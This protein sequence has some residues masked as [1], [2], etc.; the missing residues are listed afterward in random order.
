MGSN[1]ILFY[2]ASAKTEATAADAIF[3]HRALLGPFDY[4]QTDPGLDYTSGVVAQ[5]NKLLAV[6]HHI[7]LVARPQSTGIERDVQ[8][9][10]RFIRELCLS[11]TLQEHWSLPRILAVAQFLINEDPN[12]NS[13][14]SPADLKFGRRD[15]A[16]LDIITKADLDEPAA[17]RKS[18]HHRHLLAELFEIRS[19]WSRLKAEWALDKTAP[20]LLAP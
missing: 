17:Q 20:N 10:K 7:G 12:E 16:M 19:I 1:F 4:L 11:H 9:A 14:F 5:V 15:A 6:H 2:A 8:E 3:T 13:E 18:R